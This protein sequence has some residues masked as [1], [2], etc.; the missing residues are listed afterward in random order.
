MRK[1]LISIG[2]LVMLAGGCYCK[3]CYDMR[4]AWRAY[5]YGEYTK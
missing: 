5:Y 1:L 4:C 3:V 2:I